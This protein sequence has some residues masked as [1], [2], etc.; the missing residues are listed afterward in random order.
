MKDRGQTDCVTVL[1]HP[2]KLDIDL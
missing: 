1:P 2:Y